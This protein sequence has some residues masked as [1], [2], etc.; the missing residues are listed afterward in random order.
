MAINDSDLPDL[1]QEAEV[2]VNPNP[3]LKEGEGL[4]GD[5]A[6]A[7][8]SAKLDKMLGEETPQE[9]GDE[10][11]KPAPVVKP[12]KGKEEK[13]TPEAKTGAA[14]RRTGQVSYGADGSVIG[15]D[16]KVIAKPGA[17]RRH[18]ERARQQ[19]QR[20]VA[21]ER[22]VAELNQRV[23]QAEQVLHAGKSLN[24]QADE[25]LSA[26]KLFGWYKREPEAM[27][28]W[29]LTE[30]Q[31]AGYNMQTILGQESSGVNIDAIGKMID[32]RLKPVTD[33]AAE[34]RAH[35]QAY[36]AAEQEL[37]SFYQQFPDAPVH[38]DIIAR[39]INAM[40]QQ[41]G[42]TLS[43]R[44]AYLQVENWAIRNGLDMSRPLEAQLEAKK[45]G[46]TLNQARRTAPQMPR[47]RGGQMDTVRQPTGSFDEFSTDDIVK[48]A[49]REQGI[50]I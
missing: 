50:R 47:G 3:N 17:E 33:S 6:E 15:P 27:L 18:Y 36:R 16:G 24:L 30:A 13:P 49:M 46:K 20:A 37:S 4:K 32:Q 5:D 35:E 29:L 39:T 22:S 48:T 21:A 41:H 42:V 26:L 12:V 44:E 40:E 25:Q 28:K 38:E 2:E 43:L 9:E 31:A 34:R 7:E 11:E 14:D 1:D 8:L 23:A 45:A 19:E 10:D